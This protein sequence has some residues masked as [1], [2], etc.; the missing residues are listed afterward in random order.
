[1]AHVSANPNTK[2]NI[3]LKI[4]KDRF[5]YLVD[6]KGNFYNRKK[7]ESMITFRTDFVRVSAL[8]DRMVG[9]TFLRLL[10]RAREDDGEDQDVRNPNG[11]AANRAQAPGA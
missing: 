2:N 1:M 6:T 3:I 5:F 11:P 10:D 4:G 9:L 7:L 8:L